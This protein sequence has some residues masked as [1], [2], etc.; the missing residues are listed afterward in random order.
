MA[1]HAF[2]AWLFDTEGMTVWNAQWY[3]GHHVLGYSMLF[4]PLAAWPGPA[5]VGRAR[6][7]GGHRRVRAA[8]ARGGALAGRG[9]R[10]H[11]AVRRRRAQQRGDRPDAVHAR[12]RARGGG[13]A[14]RRR[15]P[16][17]RGACWPPC[18]RSPACWPA[19]SPAPSWRSPR[20]RARPAAAARRSGSRRRWCC[21]WPS[22][23]RRWRCCS[24]RAATTASW[25]PRSGRCWRSSVAGAALLAPGRRAL[26]AGVDPLPR[27][28]GRARSRS[29]TPFGQNALRLPVL[30]GPRAAAAGPARRRSA[31]RDRRRAGRARVPAVAAGRAR[32]GRG[33]RRPVDR[34][35]V[36]RRPARVPRRRRAAGRARRGGVHAQPLGGRP[37]RHRRAAGARLGAP[38]RREGQPALLR[39]PAARRR[40][41]TTAGCATRRCAGSRCR[42]RRS[43]TRPRPRRGCSSAGCRTCGWRTQSADWRIWEVRDAAPPASNGARVTAVGPGGLRGRVR[44]ADRRAPALHALV[45]LRRRLREPRARRLDARDAGPRRAGARARGLPDERRARLRRRPRGSSGGVETALAGAAHRRLNIGW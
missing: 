9:D 7:G 14:V 32:R 12:H 35:G 40:S 4:A 24:R 36:L 37:P 33:A 31:R 10:G 25:P 11:V 5:W 18:W 44:R 21:R 3:G 13:L 8:G 28:A 43:T 30:L 19:L 15:G 45:E 1:A 34:G 6:R 39:R 2:R 26:R 16:R 41:A 38:A 27:R 17:S 23:A 29:R 20:R 22:A 42:T